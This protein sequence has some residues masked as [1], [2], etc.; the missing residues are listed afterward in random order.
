MVLHNQPLPERGPKAVHILE[1]SLPQQI[2]VQLQNF[3]LTPWWHRDR[4]PVY[5]AQ[6]LTRQWRSLPVPVSALELQTH[7]VATPHVVLT[8]AVVLIIKS[9]NAYC[10]PLIAWLCFGFFCWW[11]SGLL[12]RQEQSADNDLPVIGPVFLTWPSGKGSGRMSEMLLCRLLR[13][14]PLVHIQSIVVQVF[15]HCCTYSS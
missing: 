5:E 6:I 2:L 11:P 9:L 12:P 4:E 7:S 8:R 14:T 15:P 10:D 13:Q 1:S 3:W